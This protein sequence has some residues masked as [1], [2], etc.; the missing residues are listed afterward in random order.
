[1]AIKR[2]YKHHEAMNMGWV[3]LCWGVAPN[4]DAIS[5]LSHKITVT[6]GQ[7]GRTKM[8]MLV[9]NSTNIRRC[10]NIVSVTITI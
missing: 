4:Q 2:Y 7:G 10:T 9:Y 3:N 6:F 1:M 5:N 8:C